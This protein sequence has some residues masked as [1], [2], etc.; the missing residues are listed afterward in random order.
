[1]IVGRSSR[2]LSH[3]STRLSFTW[4][5]TTYSHKGKNPASFLIQ[6]SATDRANR[7]MPCFARWHWL[8][9]LSLEIDG[10]NPSRLQLY[11]SCWVQWFKYITLPGRWFLPGSSLVVW[12][13]GSGPP[14]PPQELSLLA[15][16]FARLSD[17]GCEPIFDQ[18]VGSLTP[19]AL[20]GPRG[21]GMPWKN[22][23]HG[24]KERRRKDWVE[25]LRMCWEGVEKVLRRCW[26]CVEC[27]DVRWLLPKFTN[28]C[29]VALP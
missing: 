22:K 24:E 8:P 9:D 6:S 29:P 10:P 12:S 27:V 23:E 28:W 13:M 3:S 19:R 14:D 18:I 21:V 16:S 26:V 11:C 17:P 15:L 5:A 25:K 1:M 2:V 20:A 4:Y 7:R